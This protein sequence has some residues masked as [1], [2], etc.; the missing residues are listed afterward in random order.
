MKRLNV[1][2]Y[3]LRGDL[4]YD[5]RADMWLSVEDGLA[6]VGYDPLGL[7]INGTL[8]ALVLAEPGRQVARGQ[9]AGSLEAEKF[10][11]PVTAPV[12][13]VV[14]AVNEEAVAN[15]SKIYADPYGSWLLAIRMSDPSE[16]DELVTG[17]ALNESFAQR[18]QAYRAQGVLA[19]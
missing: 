17:D 8:A 9:A 6:K 11:G 10:V 3:E 4:Y 2:G 12:S 18:L 7:E 1:E 14:E 5:A 16:L 13:G 15:L 19:R